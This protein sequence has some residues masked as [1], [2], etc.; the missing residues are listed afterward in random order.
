MCWGLSSMTLSVTICLHSPQTRVCPLCVRTL[1][2]SRLL[3]WKLVGCFL[4]R[5]L[6]FFGSAFRTVCEVDSLLWLKRSLFFFFG[7]TF[8]TVCK[9]A[10]LPWLRRLLSFFFGSAFRT[11]CK[12]VF[13]FFWFCLPDYMCP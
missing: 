10:S 8:Q 13:L 9:V 5:S 1:L 7:S 12:V 11:M 3:L 6:F 2:L 4:R